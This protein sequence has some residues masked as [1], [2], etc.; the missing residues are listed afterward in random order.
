MATTGLSGWV[1]AV[2]RRGAWAPILVFVL[3]VVLTRVFDLYLFLPAFDVPMHFFGGIAIT[4]FAS[5]AAS[6]AASRD[7]LGRPNR[8]TLVLL[9]F[10]AGCSVTVFWEFAEFLSDRYL[11]THAQQGLPDT[12]LDMFLGVVGCAVLLLLQHATSRARGR[13]REELQS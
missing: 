12:I 6:E 9:T 2:S 13:A 5:V 1:A 7:L 11:G 3:H 10:L 4:Y 8:L